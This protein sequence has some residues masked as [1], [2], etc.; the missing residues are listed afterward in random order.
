[1]LQTLNYIS[2]REQTGLAILEN[3]GISYANLVLDP[4]F[5]LERNEWD[6]IVSPK[7]DEKYL[8]VY[9]FENNPL[10]KDFSKKIAAQ[11]NL[12]IY[13]IKDYFINPYADVHIKNAG[14][15][16]FLGLVKNCEVFLSNSFH[17]TAFSIIYEKEFYV[18]N[19]MNSPVNSRMADLLENLKLENRLILEQKKCIMQPA[20]DYAKVNCK[21]RHLISNSKKYIDEIL[22]SKLTV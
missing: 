22:K 14:P 2:V 19:R 5:L 12:K 20:I 16:E 7:S 8:L 4:V 1:M 3:L 13:G 17:G 6:R 9:D 15:L 18:F 10:I 21:L 11:K